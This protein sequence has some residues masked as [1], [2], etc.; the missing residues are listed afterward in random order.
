MKTALGFMSAKHQRIAN[1]IGL[2]EK[3]ADTPATFN[4]LEAKT[5]TLKPSRL[6]PHSPHAG[7]SESEASVRRR[8]GAEAQA[9]KPIATMGAARVA[10]KASI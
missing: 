10:G 5:G 2:L 8:C 9:L 4:E 6:I 7:A 1:E 3:H